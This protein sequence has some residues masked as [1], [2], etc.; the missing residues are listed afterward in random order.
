MLV[1]PEEQVVLSLHCVNIEWVNKT[2][3]DLISVN[4]SLFIELYGAK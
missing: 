1:A 2:N 4:A 3:L